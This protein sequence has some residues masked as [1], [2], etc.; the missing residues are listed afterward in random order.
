M[1]T[2]SQRPTHCCP[3]HSWL[4]RRQWACAALRRIIVLGTGRR[5]GWGAGAHDRRRGADHFAGTGR[6]TARLRCRRARL[7]WRWRG[8]QATRSAR[9][10]LHTWPLAAAASQPGCRLRSHHHLRSAKRGSAP[11]VSQA[12]DLE[13]QLGDLRIQGIDGCFAPNHR[14][15]G[16]DDRHACERAERRGR[17]RK[18]CGKVQKPPGRSTDDCERNEHEDFCNASGLGRAGRIRRVGWLGHG[19]TRNSLVANDDRENCPADQ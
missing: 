14:V 11:N 12:A 2:G 3:I 17:C 15:D 19:A 7:R 18:L 10:R 1:Y 4:G 16:N 9:G 13:P 6:C 8:P 5:D